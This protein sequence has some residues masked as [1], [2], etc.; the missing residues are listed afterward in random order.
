MVP[1][2]ISK[3]SKP[4]D[5]GQLPNQPKQAKSGKAPHEM[6]EGSLFTSPFGA[7]GTLIISLII[8]SESRQAVLATELNSPRCNSRHAA[9]PPSFPGD[10]GA[11]HSLRGVLYGG[12]IL[13]ITAGRTTPRPCPSSVPAGC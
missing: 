9:L 2:P 8:I 13:S 6:L 1:L 3:P 4:K 7:F 11:S 10:S 12:T 5:R